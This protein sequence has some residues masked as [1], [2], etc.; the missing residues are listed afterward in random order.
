VRHIW[1]AI[2]VCQR[3]LVNERERLQSS[4]TDSIGGAGASPAGTTATLDRTRDAL[5]EIDA[6]L[7]AITAARQD[8]KDLYG[9]PQD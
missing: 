6:E 8:Y 7:R 5:E 4:Q 2:D 3:K 9:E 1:K